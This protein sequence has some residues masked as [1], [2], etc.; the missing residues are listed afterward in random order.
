ML[1]KF[2]RSKW[3]YVLRVTTDFGR[4]I[5]ARGKIPLMTAISIVYLVVHI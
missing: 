3:N 5:F 1:G 4:K 2:N